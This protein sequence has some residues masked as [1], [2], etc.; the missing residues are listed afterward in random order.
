MS[1][2]LSCAE[3]DRPSTTSCLKDLNV[4]K[5]E[6]YCLLD[7]DDQKSFS[8]NITRAATDKKKKK[9]RPQYFSILTTCVSRDAR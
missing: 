5:D 8:F 3:S 9:W 2:E 4:I 1:E 7:L 6:I